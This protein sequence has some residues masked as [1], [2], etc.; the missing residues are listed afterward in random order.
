MRAAA[1]RGGRALALEGMQRFDGHTVLVTGGGRGLGR[2]VALVFASLGAR[3]ALVSRS[4]EQVA[5]AAAAVEARGARAL[6]AALDVTDAAALARFLNQVEQRLG[7]LDVLV[8]NAALIEPIAPIWR[9]DAAAWLRNLEVGL[10]GAFLALRLVAPDM[11]ARR[12]GCVVNVT[13]GAGR[14]EARVRGWSAYSTAKAGL[15]QLTRL[16]DAELRPHGVRVLGFNPGLVNTDPYEGGWMLKRVVRR[17]S[18]ELI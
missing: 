11:V 2:G 10:G 18:A 16:A 9:V 3:V 13:S 15:D 4:P 6:G 12:R 1:A 14:P 8:N 7:P 17:D 5:E